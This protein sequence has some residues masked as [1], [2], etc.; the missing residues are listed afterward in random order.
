MGCNEP[1]RSFLTSFAG[2]AIEDS[3]QPERLFCG[4]AGRQ[5]NRIPERIVSRSTERNPQ[6][7]KKETKN[8]VSNTSAVGAGIL[9]GRRQRHPAG[10]TENMAVAG[11]FVFYFHVCFFKF[12]L[13]LLWAVKWNVSRTLTHLHFR[14]QHPA[15]DTRNGR[16]GYETSGTQ[17]DAQVTGHT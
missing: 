13:V 3:R 14:S 8:M 4:S 11:L 2:L 1:T 9:I 17:V 12:V 5:W 15:V 7:N 16:R 10:P 6:R